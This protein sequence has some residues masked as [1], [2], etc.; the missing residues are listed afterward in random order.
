[1]ARLTTTGPVRFAIF[2]TVALCGG[3]LPSPSRAAP[4][5]FKDSAVGVRHQIDAGGRH[6]LPEIMGGGVAL[7]DVD[8][9]GRL[10]LFF[11]NGGPI[12]PEPGRR[13]PCRYYRNNGDGTFTDATD[14]RHAPGPSYAM[15]A[16]VGDFDGDG[17]DDL[18][19]TG[20]RDQRLYRNVGEGR[21]EDVTARAGLTFEPL[22]HLGRLRRPR[23]RRRPRPVRRRLPRLRPGRRPVLRGPRR[24]SRL[25][26]P[27]GLPR[28][29]RPALPQQRRRH[30]HRRLRA[31]GIDLPEGRGLGVLVADLI[32]D[33]RPDIFVANDGTACWLF[34]N[35]GGLRFGKSAL[36]AGVAFDGRGDALAGMGVALGDLDGDGR[37]DLV[38]SNFLGRTTVAFRVAGRRDV[39]RRTPPSS[40]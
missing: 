34:E 26:R 27:R 21:F 23:R 4:L 38:V 29:A 24:P 13:P 19:V 11:C 25:L 22:E 17:R 7:I 39:R 18:F 15:G 14:R 3:I 33:A 10:D 31:A 35:H 5:S 30:V 20:W 16:A 8:G 9:D 2:S 32:G 1:M 28:P 12:V 36:A 6:D 40:A 37:S